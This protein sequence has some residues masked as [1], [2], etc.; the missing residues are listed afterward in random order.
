[1]HLSSKYR[2][3]FSLHDQELDVILK[4]LEG[5]ELTDSEID[6]ALHMAKILKRVTDMAPDSRQ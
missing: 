4:C 3:T 2:W 1:M 6:K 5:E